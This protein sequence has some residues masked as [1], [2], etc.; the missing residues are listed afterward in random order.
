MPTPMNMELDEP[1]EE[2]NGVKHM[3]S[4]EATIQ[5]QSPPHVKRANKDIAPTPERKDD[6]SDEDGTNHVTPAKEEQKSTRGNKDP[7]RTK[8]QTLYSFLRN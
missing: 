7:K 3:S 2:H 5:I 6:A 8:G 4:E 1:G